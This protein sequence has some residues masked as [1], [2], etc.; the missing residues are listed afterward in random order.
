MTPET[1]SSIPAT[2]PDCIFCKIA[3]GTIP[4]RVE[5]QDEQCVVIHDQNP[6]APVHLLVI[7][8]QH[9]VNVAACSEAEQELLGHL[10]LVAARLARKIGI[11]ETGYR[12]VINNGSGAG[13]SVWHLHLHLLGGRTF[14]WPP[15]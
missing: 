14:Q 7:P 3:A 5:H 13:Q 10:H 9:V 1:A 11:E 8:K 12:L 4:A 15:G 6:A 2:A